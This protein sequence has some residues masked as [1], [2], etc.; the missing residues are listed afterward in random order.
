MILRLTGVIPDAAGNDTKDRS[1]K[2]KRGMRL[3]SS[4]ALRASVKFT[5]VQYKPSFVVFLALAWVIVLPGV[6]DAGWLIFRNDTK[7]PVIVQGTSIV[8]GVLRQKRQ[9]LQP[10]ETW[11][12]ATV[13]G[14]KLIIIADAKQPTRILYRDTI[15]VGQA[16]INVS[17][18][19]DAV[20]QPKAKPVKVK[21]TLKA[22]QPMPVSKV[23]LVPVKEPEDEDPVKPAARK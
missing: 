20:P 18:Q 22:Q 14:N 17:I 3:L 13:R 21:S 7:L 2:R 5:S 6:A 11:R 15:I 1:P 4:L 8:N 16:D 23:K 9:I 10:G 19:E 12:E